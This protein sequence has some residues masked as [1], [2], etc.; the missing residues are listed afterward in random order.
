MSF[1]K[2]SKKRTMSEQKAAATINKSGFILLNGKCIDEYIPKAAYVHLF[3]D[4]KERLVGLKPH[5]EKDRDSYSLTRIRNGTTR[6]IHAVVFFRHYGIVIE[7]T[8]R[9]E[10]RW[11]DKSGFLVLDLKT[12]RT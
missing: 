5:G 12:P 9:F 1:E 6:V 3:F 11:D 4:P 8:R 10:P 7:K 2:Y